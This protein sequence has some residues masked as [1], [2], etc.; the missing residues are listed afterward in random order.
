MYTEHMDLIAL[1]VCCSQYYNA[2]NIV[3]YY[4]V[5]NKIYSTMFIYRNYACTYIYT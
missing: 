1:Y 4:N 3:L 2:Y 5:I